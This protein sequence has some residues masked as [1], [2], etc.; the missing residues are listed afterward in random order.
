MLS[1]MSF[2]PTISI[3]GASFYAG[4][5]LHPAWEGDL[6]FASLKA[7]QLHRVSLAPPDF[8]AVETS[9]ILFNQELG[10]LRAVAVSP[11]RYLYF[12]TSNRTSTDRQQPGNDKLMRLLPVPVGQSV[13]YH[14]A[15]AGS[16]SLELEPGACQVAWE[17]NGYSTHEE[18]V[19]IIRD[20]SIDQIRLF[21]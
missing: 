15:S 18:R 2:T 20:E 3:S 5:K 21:P 16:F 12:T 14:P 1:I 7:S 11:D 9:H 19:I 4:D 10:R 8:R 6:I 17:A 13:T